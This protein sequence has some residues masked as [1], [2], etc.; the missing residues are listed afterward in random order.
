[1][2][3]RLRHLALLLILPL[4]IAGGFAQAQDAQ[5]E[6]TT[7][8]APAETAEGKSS[9]ELL[10]D[11]IEDDTARAQLIDELRAA[12]AEAAPTDDQVVET[13]AEAAGTVA[14]AEDISFGRRIALI[15]QGI[16]EEA[17]AKVERLWSQ[18]SQSSGVFDGLSGSEL[19]VL[20]DAAKEL[21]LVIAATVIVFMALRRIGK[22]I[23]ARMG[24]SARDGGVMRTI[25][26]Y[27]ASALIDTLNVLLAWAA[28]Y[29]IA[30]LLL[31]NFGQIG[32]RQTL[33]LNAFLIVE[34]ARV[35]LRLVLSPS[36]RSLRPIPV[37][38][39]AA[40]YMS[41][42][43]GL[44]IAMVGYGQLLIVPII[45]AQVSFAAGRAI[46]TLIA[47]LV[48]AF[49]VYLVLRNRRAVADWM[50][51]DPQPTPAPTPPLE[52]AAAN[53]DVAMLA[54]EEAAALAGWEDTQSIQP[55]VEE[56]PKP[57]GA[58][59]F[60]ALHW[61]WPALAYLFAMFVLVLVS[62]GNAVLN[63]FLA[64][65]QVLV[66]GLLGFAIS[67]LIGGIMVRGI[68]LPDNV[69][70]RLPLLE[71]RINRFVPKALFVLRLVILALVILFVLN[72]L[73]IIDLRA[74]MASQLGLR[75][76]GSALSVAAILLVSFLVWLGLNSWVDYR[77]NPEFGNVA[78]AREQTLLTLLRNAATIALLIVTLMFVLSEIGLDIA[79]LLASA[80]VL[81]LAIGF[82][83]QKLVQDIITGIFIQFENAMNVGDVVTVG[84]TTGTIEKLTIRS[85][86][87][88]DVSGVF[89]LIPFSSVD[90]V[91][92]YVRDFGYFV[93]D[94]GVAYRENSEEVRQA[95][96]DAFERLRADPEVDATIVGP[97]EWFGLNSFG[98]S[99][100]NFRARIKCVPGKQWG[101][102]RAYNAVVKDVF[103]E[104]GIE[105]PF[106]YRT[107][108]LGE[109]K[110]GSTQP[111]RITKDP[112]T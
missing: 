52:T 60:L 111:L 51:G 56:P 68:A 57:R 6:G 92:N 29:A 79:P 71:S 88:R 98:D 89:H 87:L 5:S 43:L 19:S 83:A 78:T 110:D 49:A 67:G 103:D 75:I 77:L 2:T 100:V 7:A 12:G 107:L 25:A 53:R 36:S 104:R 74:W 102:G 91:S 70:Q 80:G 85:V 28:G 94:M 72:S 35:A 99:S 76:T 8:E 90:M 62:P 21:A 82:G 3:T 40:R 54:P 48:L 23:Y 30:T 61:H 46:S 81:G 11:V 33:Y 84:G 50:L 22:T 64:S 15:T 86:S 73:S 39:A 93:C 55:V 44:I 1:M 27:L 4:L 58:A 37:G 24:A 20:L 59:S 96:E 95:M 66:I 101:V 109:A 14:P 65:G 31:G 42:W 34:M 38:N 9:L 112:E 45:N 69:N 97:F 105:I 41:R 47:F 17:A 18:L 63:T 32:I 16:A 108:V 10:L 26:L 106:P 13:V